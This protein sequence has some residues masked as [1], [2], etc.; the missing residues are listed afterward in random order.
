MKILLSLNMYK[1]MCSELINGKILKV[2]T[3]KAS[4]AFKNQIHLGPDSAKIVRYLIIDLNMI[5][6]YKCL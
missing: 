1:C 2:K 3:T 6:I 5:D 4:S